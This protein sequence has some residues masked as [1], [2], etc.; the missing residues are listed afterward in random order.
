MTSQHIISLIAASIALIAT[1]AHLL[2]ELKR[3][4][5][6]FQ[7]NSYR[8]SRYRGWLNESKDTTSLWRLAGMAIWFIALSSL[9]H[10]A[11]SLTL[12]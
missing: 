1:T 6:M 5:M 3:D 9:S 8:C 2:L 12:F 10:P 7:Q 11:I 4:L